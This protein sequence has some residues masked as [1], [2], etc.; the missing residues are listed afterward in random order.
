[1]GACTI[2][3][4]P[5]PGFLSSVFV[6][7]RIV[8]ANDSGWT[9]FVPSNRT[10]R[11]ILGIIVPDRWGSLW[12]FS[13]SAFAPSVAAADSVWLTWPLKRY[14]SAL[15]WWSEYCS[16][17]PHWRR[18]C[19]LRSSFAYLGGALK[20]D[21]RRNLYLRWR[22]LPSVVHRVTSRDGLES[23]TFHTRAYTSRISYYGGTVY[24]TLQ[25]NPHPG[26][27]RR[28]L[29]RI[30]A[31]SQAMTPRTASAKF[32]KA[33]CVAFKQRHYFWWHHRWRGFHI[34]DLSLLPRR[35]LRFPPSPNTCST[36][37]SVS[38]WA[39]C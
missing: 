17:P 32:S 16:I 29:P 3:T 34:D 23:T 33:E 38:G 13:S 15:A 39:E 35:F 7:W 31:I 26:H 18:S 4:V 28:I 9:G 11:N 37:M 36:T 2:C 22:L 21:Y 10:S 20:Y 19:C 25:L 5:G 27:S 12:V 1:M 6:A 8:S 24:V 30:G 14:L